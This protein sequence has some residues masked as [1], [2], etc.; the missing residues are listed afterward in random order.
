[1][2]NIVSEI[3][4]NDLINQNLLGVVKGVLQIASEQ[5]LPGENH[6]YITFK[7]NFQGVELPPL[8]SSR[9]PETM[10]IVLQHQFSDLTVK[11][12]FFSV[13]L[14]FGGVP[15]KL[16]VP[17]KAVTYFADPYAKFGLAFES[18]ESNDSQREDNQK[19]IPH[20]SAEI[21][22]IDSFRKKK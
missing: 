11:N 16:V 18:P 17:F 22:S 10:T 4:Y 7:T 21:V 8:L 2:E 12:N 9:Y 6:F 1:M 15:Y 14:V 3:D 5:G 20:P 13:V 19:D